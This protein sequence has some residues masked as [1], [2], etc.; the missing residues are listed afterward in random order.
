MPTALAAGVEPISPSQ[1]QALFAA[2]QQCVGTAE[3]TYR[4][5][6]ASSCN[7]SGASLDACKRAAA[8]FTQTLTVFAAHLRT[9]PWPLQAR[10]AAQGLAMLCDE[11]ISIVGGPA[12]RA[13]HVETLADAISGGD[14]DLRRIDA[15]MTSVSGLLAHATNIT[16][17]PASIPATP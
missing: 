11:Y 2:L 12:T 8:A 4:T 5:A 7:G 15:T 1:G 3:Q 16:G 17:V 14:P 13:Q 6:V 10:G 9:T